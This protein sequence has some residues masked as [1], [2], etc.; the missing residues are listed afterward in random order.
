MI[1]VHNWN[2]GTVLGAM[3]VF[4][5]VVILIWM[6]IR[7]FHDIWL[8]KDIHGGA[9]AGWILL[10]VL[11]PLFGIVIYIVARPKGLESME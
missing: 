6:F 9:K 3:L 7:V 10:I 1:G 4:Y 11:V 8:R 2:F 5:F